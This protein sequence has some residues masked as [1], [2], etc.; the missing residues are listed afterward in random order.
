MVRIQLD[1]VAGQ[2]VAIRIGECD[3]I[4]RIQ[5]DSVA[6][7]CVGAGIGHRDSCAVVR[8]RV[9]DQCVAIGVIE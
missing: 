7:Q 6:G 1:S 2:R 8:D 3:P 9:A 5:L 4:V